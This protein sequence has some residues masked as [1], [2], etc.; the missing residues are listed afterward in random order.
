MGGNQYES[1]TVADLVQLVSQH[2]GDHVSST[3][4]GGAADKST[5][6]S[7][8]LLTKAG[9]SYTN[10]YIEITSGIT[11]VRQ[12]NTSAIS[13][14]TLTITPYN[15]F[16]A[17]IVANTFRIHQFDPTWKIEAINETLRGFREAPLLFSEYLIVG[18]CLRNRSFEWWRTSSSPYDWK[19]VTGTIAKETSTIYDGAAALSIGSAQANVEQ[20][21]KLEGL[22]EGVT[23]T[24][25]A[26][27]KGNGVDGALIRLA[28]GLNTGS[29]STV[30]TSQ[31]WQKL[32]ATFTILDRYQPIYARI[33]NFTTTVL[34]VD[35]CRVY[36]PNTDRVTFLPLSDYYKQLYKV[37]VGPRSDIVYTL[38]K[39]FARHDMP[40]FYQ[41][42]YAWFTGNR[43]KIYP[44]PE[45]INQGAGG[46][47]PNPY[48]M[49]L[50][51]EGRYPT[52][53]ASTDTVEMTEES[54]S[55]LA[56]KAAIRVLHK[57]KG[58][59][60]FADKDHWNAVERD[61]LGL[62]AEMEPRLRVA[63]P[64]RRLW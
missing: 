45:L 57:A 39:D 30:G 20:R 36:V 38:T 32:T 14:G 37:D 10:R 27:V 23:L 41:D 51:G 42:G 12:I 35:N 56:A 1:Y 49:R 34:Y 40:S 59:E 29:S 9:A 15:V 58:A 5:L 31:D 61:I 50:S 11:D 2:L 17:Q 21:L 48:W 43:G 28:Q 62:I 60:H 25:T 19:V 33:L 44:Y 55:L 52:V 54:A 6:T 4:S 46:V 26:Y 3:A 16:S 47:L 13:S 63:R 53:T 24:F 7:T 18:E 8:A 64:S 22:L